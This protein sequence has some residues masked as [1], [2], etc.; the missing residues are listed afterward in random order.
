MEVPLAPREVGDR[1]GQCG[2]VSWVIRRRCDA[3][4]GGL[5]Q[6][7]DLGYGRRHTDKLVY[8]AVLQSNYVNAIQSERTVQR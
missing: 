6:V 2:V 7:E 8:C 4:R 5:G 1:R 3:Q